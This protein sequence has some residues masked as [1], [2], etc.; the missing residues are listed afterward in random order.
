MKKILGP[1]CF[2]RE[3]KEEKVILYQILEEDR[4]LENTSPLIL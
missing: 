1:Y 4:K 3:I 2:T